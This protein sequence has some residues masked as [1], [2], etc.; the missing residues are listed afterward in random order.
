MNIAGLSY[1][2]ATAAQ[3]F[4]LWFCWKSFCFQ[5]DCWLITEDKGHVAFIS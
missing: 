4:V 3:L 1:T 2:L 5:P